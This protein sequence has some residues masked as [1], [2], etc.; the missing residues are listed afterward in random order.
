VS[1][2]VQAELAGGTASRELEGKVAVVTGGARGIGR[3]IAEALAA[4]GSTVVVSDVTQDAATATAAEI[5]GA[6]A[7]ACDVSDEGQVA[8][9]FA[10]ALARHGRVDIAVANAGISGLG[11]LTELSF[12]DWRK[13]MAVNLDGVFLT[14]KH[15]ARAMVGAGNGGSIITM[16]SVTGLAGSPLTGH[17]AAAK[18]G[19]INLTKTAALELRPASVRVNAICPGFADTELVS[20]QKGEYEQALGLPSFDALIEQAQGGYVKLDDIAR[21]TVFLASERSRFC[22]GGA[23]VVDGGLTASMM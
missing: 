22:T 8:E 2:Q 14:V 3:A 12:E 6:D 9:L 7:V 15:A 18:A 10:G 20:S 17:Y 23:F 1:V 5:D 11:P 19:V 13:M 16:A 4:Q 21:L